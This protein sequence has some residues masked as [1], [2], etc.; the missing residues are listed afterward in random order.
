LRAIGTGAN[1]D[2]RTAPISRDQLWQIVEHA[3]SRPSARAGA[4]IALAEGLDDAGRVRLQK[5][6]GATASP[7]IRVAIEKA[8]TSP[9]DEELREALAE[10]EQEEARD[11][12]PSAVVETELAL[13][14][15]KGDPV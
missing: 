7:K 8:A 12:E 6:A 4:A 1:A 10:L 3:G 14:R 11:A 9:S 5:A 13:E 15:A 2:H